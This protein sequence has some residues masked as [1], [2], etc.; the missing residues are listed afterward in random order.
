MNIR[1][2]CLF[3]IVIF[4]VLFTG[5]SYTK[6]AQV[7]SPQKSWDGDVVDAS[8]AIAHKL[9]NNLRT[10]IAHEDSI[11]VASFVN[12]SDLT[13]SSHFG[14]IMSEQ[15]ASRLAQKGYKVIE[16]KLRQDSIFVDPKNKGEFLLSRNIKDISRDHN[17]SAVVVGTYAQ[18]YR[19]VYVSARI[20][21]P[22]DSIILSSCDYEL[23][24]PETREMTV[25]MKE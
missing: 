11:I 25:L 12:V 10:P 21:S 18:G 2:L 8:Y 5:C 22:F 17:A 7:V 20:I 4:S 15:V 24:F 1:A 19:K 23:R 14:R 16:M 3:V 9:E 13:K 6:Q